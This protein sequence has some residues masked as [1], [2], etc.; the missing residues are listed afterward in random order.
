VKRAL[1]VVEKVFGI[2]VDDAN[3]VQIDRGFHS[4][5]NMVTG[6][7]T[8]IKNQ[9]Y[10]V[11]IPE[12]NAVLFVANHRDRDTFVFDKQ[13]LDQYYQ[14]NP[15]LR[16]EDNLQFGQNMLRDL[17]AVSGNSGGA[18]KGYGD[19]YQSVVKQGAQGVGQHGPTL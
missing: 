10:R 4:T 19:E 3:R 9:Y 13:Q 5:E 7:V 2:E 8:L 6:N 18:I 11:A 16:E 15:N 17:M 1:F 14:D 12:L